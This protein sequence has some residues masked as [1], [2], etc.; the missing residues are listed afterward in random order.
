VQKN[1]KEFSERLN[2]CLDDLDFPQNSRERSLILS[3]MLHISKQQ[4]WSLLEG[5]VQPDDALL[6]QLAT[7]LEVDV[8]TFIQSGNDE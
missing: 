3:R 7:E 6:Q 2:K 8:E 1:A 4:A 5:H